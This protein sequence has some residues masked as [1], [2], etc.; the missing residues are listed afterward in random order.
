MLNTTETDAFWG[1]RLMV[2]QIYQDFATKLEKAFPT[3]EVDVQKNQILFLQDERAFCY[4]WRPIRKV[5]CT[6]QQYIIVSFA[7]GKPLESKRLLKPSDPTKKWY[8][9]HVLVASDKDV[10]EELLDWLQAAQ[11]FTSINAKKKKKPR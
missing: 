6:P 2:R 4:V 10:D 8:I 11:R 5:R 7:L 9:H 3:A 1:K